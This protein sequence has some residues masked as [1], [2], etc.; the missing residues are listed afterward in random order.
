MELPDAKKGP[1]L[2]F[3]L[4]SPKALLFSLL[5]FTLGYCSKKYFNFP[6]AFTST[7]VLLGFVGLFRHIYSIYTIFMDDVL[8]QVFGLNMNSGF[9]TL[10]IRQFPLHSLEEIERKGLFIRLRFRQYGSGKLRFAP[11]VFCRPF[12]Q[13]NLDKSNEFLGQINYHTKNA[14]PELISVSQQQEFVV[15]RQ[16]FVKSTTAFSKKSLRQIFDVYCAELNWHH[17]KF[18]QV[19]TY[20]IF[21]YVL[22]LGGAFLWW[23]LKFHASDF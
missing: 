13:H 19:V 18:W 17:F 11:D 23:I 6:S 9:L 7:F 20:S 2:F 10:W 1:K 8:V 12:S 5:F 21:E 14:F 15:K 4:M 16:S 3:S 22:F